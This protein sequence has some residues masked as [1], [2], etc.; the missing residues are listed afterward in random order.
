MNQRGQQVV[1]GVIVLL[2]VVL[3]LILPPGPMVNTIFICGLGAMLFVIFSMWQIELWKNNSPDVIWP[4]GRG[5]LRDRHAGIVELEKV[6]DSKRSPFFPIFFCG[7]HYMSLKTTKPKFVMIANEDCIEVDEGD[8]THYYI[9]AQPDLFRDVPNPDTKEL[10]WSNLP[11]RF[12]RALAELGIGRDT[13]VYVAWDPKFAPLNDPEAK[14]LL[15]YKDL[16]MSSNAMNEHKDG[17][18]STLQNISTNV[19]ATS[20]SH[21]RVFRG[22]ERQPSLYDKARDIVTRDDERRYVE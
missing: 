21:S 2:W 14:E 15:K 3:M 4:N 6:P 11:L 1:A 13:P 7:H 16:Y 5:T 12:K 20:E 19:A 22:N 18:I 17:I 9:R 8:V 10:S